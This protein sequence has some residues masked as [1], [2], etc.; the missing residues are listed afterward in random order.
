MV[1]RDILVGIGFLLLIAGACK[2]QS[3][4]TTGSAATIK[5]SIASLGKITAPRAF[6]ADV[7]ADGRR[8]ALLTDTP[9][10]YVV[11]LDGA[12][13]KTQ[14]A[15]APA[16]GSTV[17][18]LAFRPGTDQ[19]LSS[20]GFSVAL[21]DTAT[22]K[23]TGS[24]DIQTAFK[25][26][27]LKIDEVVWSSDGGTIFAFCGIAKCLLSLRPGPTGLV[28]GGRLPLELNEYV[29]N[30]LAPSIREGDSVLLVSASGDARSWNGKD[31]TAKE[32]DLPKSA[33]YAFDTAADPAW[34]DSGGTVHLAG[35]KELPSMPLKGGEKIVRGDNSLFIANAERAIV[36]DLA[37]K[38][39]LAHYFEGDPGATAI[40][41][42]T[43]LGLFAL[44][45]K[46]HR[47]RRVTK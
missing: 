1:R 45:S 21:W 22:S 18:H 4:G 44:D 32:V 47:L 6:L 37:G 38:D 3:S 40:P 43:G 34:L 12:G 19:L 46:E 31:A 36:V 23:R 26:P 5:P 17:L 35:G 29:A 20:D 24:V 39:L 28:A 15:L 9:N 14:N 7:S 42:R 10:P 13:I 33:I 25:D 30:R 8:L 16:H 11:E 2:N 41:M 27:L